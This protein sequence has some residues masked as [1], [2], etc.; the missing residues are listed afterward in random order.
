MTDGTSNTVILNC[1]FGAGPCKH[2]VVGDCGQG[3]TN[4]FQCCWTHSVVGYYGCE[5][6]GY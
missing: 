1:P 6:N 5:N 2:A 3:M 4:I